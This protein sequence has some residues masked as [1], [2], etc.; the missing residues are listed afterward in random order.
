MSTVRSQLQIPLGFRFLPTNKE[1]LS[2]YLKPII[3]GDPIPSGV[4]MARD[5]YGANR[6]P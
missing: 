1:I 6:E 4:M 2:D 5:I 3:K